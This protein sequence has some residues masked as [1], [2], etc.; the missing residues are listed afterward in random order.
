[1]NQSWELPRPVIDA[2]SASEIATR[3]FG[4][5]GRATEL[6]SQQDRNFLIEEAGG[7]RWLLKV[8]NPAFSQAEIEA[9]NSLMRRLHERGLDV[10]HPALAIE[11][12]DTASVEL[13]EGRHVVRLLSWVDGT[14]LIERSHLSEEVLESVGDLVADVSVALA[15]FSHPGLDRVIQWDL[16][17][18][19]DVIFELL[20][21]VGDQSHRS[22]IEDATVRS[23]RAIKPVANKLPVQPVH[24]DLTDDNLVVDRE[25]MVGGI[26]DFGDAV[27]S[28]RVAELVIA[29]S[30]V[31]HHEPSRP[32]AILPLVAAFDRKVRLTDEELSVIWPL[33]V[34]RGASLVVSGL[35]Q[36]SIDPQNDYA[37]NALE[38][39]WAVFAAAHDRDADAMTAAIR[40]A[41]RPDPVRPRGWHSP[42]PLVDG[43]N[44]FD[45]VVLGYDSRTLEA[46]E[47]L[48][49]ADAVEAIQ[50]G[51]VASRGLAVT[52]FAEPRLT[53]AGGAGPEEP[54]NVPLFI[55]VASHAPVELIAPVDGRVD[56]DG[57][58]ITL[59]AGEYALI[60]EGQPQE[61]THEGEI[62][63]G[64]RI[65]V[66]DGPVRLWYL[67]VD[68]AEAMVRLPLFVRP[69]EAPGWLTGFLDPTPL[70]VGHTG[71]SK[72]TE[73]SVLTRRTE[74]YAPL[75][76]HYYRRPPR[77][78]RG[79]RE[80][81]IDV[82]GRHYLDMVNNVTV[83]GHGHP[84][85]AEAVADQWRM[86]NT[87][88]RFNY[89][90]VAEFSERLLET[91]PAAL[92]TVLLVNSGT[93][94]VDLALR[95]ARAHTGR[96]AVACVSESY[97][98]WSVAADAVSTSV[99]DNPL[100]E[101]TRPAWVHVLEAPNAY[102]GR[103]RGADAGDRYARD[104]VR[105]LEEWAAD[106]T[107]IG[108]FIAE[109]RHGNAGAIEVPDGYLRQVY[110]AIR[111][112]GGLCI[113]D[114]VQVGYG[115][116]GDVFWGFE[117]HPGVVPDIIT[118]A[119]AMGNGHPLGAVITRADIAASLAAQGTF[120]S[121]AGG[122][123]LSAKLGT[124]ILDIIRDER[125]QENAAVMGRRLLD[126]FASLAERHEI[127][128]AA[129]GRGL[130]L[131]LELVRDRNTL[132]PATSETR[133][134]CDRLLQLGVIVQ[135]TGD[136]QNVLKIK[137][138][139]CITAASVDYF[140]E[141]LDR[142]LG[143][144]V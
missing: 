9:Q 74:S 14:P 57:G 45:E 7:S 1:M 78:E 26:I 64:Q 116:Q 113:A 126:G 128:G 102:R 25:G 90:S 20:G 59:T 35:Q 137:P 34:L 115:R 24:G 79:W 16:R 109:P 8:S 82:D 140:L 133:A 19:G 47:W 112:G 91:V 50:L 89:A 92:D 15:G 114:E 131:G 51:R 80:F 127:I 66:F 37:R 58:L 95:L 72:L 2:V 63:A 105:Q 38:R 143:E 132:E 83:L 94:A 71:R 125:L 111:A 121:S 4:I 73:K 5:E 12:G 142:A 117:Q 68:R 110:S 138:P 30:F 106:G 84:R 88:S 11:G 27:E 17:R 31:L 10:P 96:K 61:R 62:S 141:A 120:F 139:L 107:P 104:A 6:G 55:D 69:S 39:E 28:W 49:D 123:T 23:L 86:L 134:L 60:I 87:N 130:Y 85:L 122:S 101:Q 119:K 135:P 48:G 75:Q 108:A 22:A 76:G 77:I 103:Y 118:V 40:A 65:A 53:R 97:H 98:G 124:T 29:C 100:A 32:L 3:T 36:V 46:G 136:R 18:A 54:V 129:H 81:M 99:S 67:L 42:G 43:I 44:E 13:S 56:A 21:F 70:I 93:E 41:I 144:I 52:R 33:L